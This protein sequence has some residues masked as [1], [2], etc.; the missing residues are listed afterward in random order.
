MLVNALWYHRVEAPMK[1]ASYR[2]EQSIP[3]VLTLIQNDKYPITDP[4]G[5]PKYNLKLNCLFINIGVCGTT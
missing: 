1:I 4:W 3:N 5:T 2:F